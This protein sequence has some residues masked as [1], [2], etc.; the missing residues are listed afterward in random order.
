ML[1]P[2]IRII[3]VNIFPPIVIGAISPYPTV[4]KVATDHHKLWNM[5]LKVSGCAGYS[6]KY[7]PTADKYNKIIVIVRN[8]NN[9]SFISTKALIYLL[10]ALV[11][12]SNFKIL[13]NLNN[14]NIRIALKSKLVV[15]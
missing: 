14:L 4:V 12:R 1:N 13:N 2:I 9:S 5:L 6:K 10:I 8:K 3:N 7:I 15:K 11:Y